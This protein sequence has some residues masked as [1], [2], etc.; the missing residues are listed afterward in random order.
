MTSMGIAPC[1]R[2]WK[3]SYGGWD[4]GGVAGARPPSRRGRVRRPRRPRSGAG[5]A[6][7]GR[8]RRQG[9]PRPTPAAR[10]RGTPNVA[11]G[12][13]GGCTLPAGVVRPGPPVM[14]E[15]T[16]PSR[17]RPDVTALAC[18]EWA[19]PPLCPQQ[20]VLPP[21]GRGN[22]GGGGGGSGSGGSDGGGVGSDGGSGIASRPAAT[23]RRGKAPVVWP[24]ALWVQRH[25]PTAWQK[26]GIGIVCPSCG[27][28]SCC[29]PTTTP[30]EYQV[31]LSETTTEATRAGQSS[32]ALPQA[33]RMF[34]RVHLDAASSTPAHGMEDFA[35]H[36][37]LRFSWHCA[38]C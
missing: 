34:S 22:G 32:Q 14:C 21:E 13:G 5:G 25:P 27:R 10:G 19:P 8:P 3:V 9:A 17:R 15:S 37:M 20:A 33:S 28:Q 18:A 38:K 35:G 2:S 26:V 12:G 6:G 16:V 29:R 24:R 31:P 7:Q 23:Q 4:V 11:V 30:K 36:G 1:A